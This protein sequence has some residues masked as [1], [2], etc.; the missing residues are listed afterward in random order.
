M[1]PKEIDY[2]DKALIQCRKKKKMKQTD[3]ASATGISR[4]MYQRYESGQ[5]VPNGEHVLIL[6][7]LFSVVFKMNYLNF[8]EI[9]SIL[10]LRQ[11]LDSSSKKRNYDNN[12]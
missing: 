2:S 9:L 12:S 10:E 4:R 7:A 8:P 5:R 11:M 3:V 6:G 1:K